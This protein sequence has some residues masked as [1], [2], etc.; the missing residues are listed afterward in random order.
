M[1]HRCPTSGY[2]FDMFLVDHAQHLI[3][4]DIL[5]PVFFETATLVIEMH[6]VDALYLNVRGWNP[7]I[8]Y[9]LTSD[10]SISLL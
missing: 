4:I 9:I 2:G 7:D 8:E 6:S 10:A 3:D 5:L 1:D